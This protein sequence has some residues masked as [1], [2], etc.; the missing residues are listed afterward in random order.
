ATQE[1]PEVAAR[2]PAGDA[3]AG[4]RG[5]RE[6]GGAGARR[7]AARPIRL[8]PPGPGPRRRARAPGR[9]EPARGA[10]ARRG[11]QARVGGAM[12]ASGGGDRGPREGERA[13]HR[14]ADAAEAGEGE[15]RRPVTTRRLEG[16]PALRPGAERRPRRRGEEAPLEGAAVGPGT[17]A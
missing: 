4:A 14:G 9:E 2:R 8:P 3:V 5:V 6:A 1:R 12:S 11:A 13:R 7:A 16:L 10:L 17:L 15:P